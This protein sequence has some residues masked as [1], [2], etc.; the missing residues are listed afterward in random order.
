MEKIREWAEDLLPENV[1]PEDYMT[2][3]SS[4]FMASEII[5][6]ADALHR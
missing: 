1:H 2:D 6:K 5:R 4:R 3:R